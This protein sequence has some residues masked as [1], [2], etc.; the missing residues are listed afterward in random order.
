MDH[1]DPACS[2]LLAEFSLTAIER[3]LG[4]KHTH[5]AEQAQSEPSTRL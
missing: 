2:F 1:N 5:E 4:D 3:L